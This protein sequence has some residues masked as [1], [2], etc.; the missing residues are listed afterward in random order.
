MILI[1]NTDKVILSV[2]M[3]DTNKVI[4]SIADTSTK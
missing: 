3:A 2:S 1:V 4:F